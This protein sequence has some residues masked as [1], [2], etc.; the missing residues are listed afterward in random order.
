[1]SREQFEW[2]LARTFA[3]MTVGA[4]I[5]GEVLGVWGAQ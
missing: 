4:A 1:M 2:M 5:A 3:L